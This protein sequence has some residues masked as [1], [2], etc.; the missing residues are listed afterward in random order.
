MASVIPAPNLL[1]QIEGVEAG[2]RKLQTIG[3]VGQLPGDRDSGDRFEVRSD[4]SGGCRLYRG[5]R[6]VGDSRRF[7]DRSAGL[8]PPLHVVEVLAQSREPFRYTCT[9]EAFTAMSH[10]A[11]VRQMEWVEKDLDEP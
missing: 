8:C 5:P 9:I 1:E 7:L 6:S 10:S 4:P 3:R 2:L 11:K